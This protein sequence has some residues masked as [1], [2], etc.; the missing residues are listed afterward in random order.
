MI[1]TLNE[2]N[3]KIHCA[4]NYDSVDICAFNEDLARIYMVR[5]L[6]R[7]YIATSEINERLVLNHVIILSNVFGNFSNNIFYYIFDASEYKYINSF[8]LFLRRLPDDKFLFGV[9]LP[10]TKKLEQL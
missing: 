1:V 10:L 3:F 8:L 9:D 4:R 2:K 6:I 7:K 5:K